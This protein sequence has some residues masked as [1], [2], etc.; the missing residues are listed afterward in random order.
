MKS[1]EPTILE[2][3]RTDLEI[4]PDTEKKLTTFMDNFSKSFA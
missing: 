1:R 2:S 3:I 4:K